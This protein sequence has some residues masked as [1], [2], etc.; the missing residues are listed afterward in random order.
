MFPGVVLAFQWAGFDMFLGKKRALS[1]A[2]DRRLV[3]VV[4]EIL[5]SMDVVRTRREN[6][7]SQHLRSLNGLPWVTLESVS[8]KVFISYIYIQTVI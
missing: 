3:T 8:K 5:G 2:Q 6:H 7:R 4:K 1:L